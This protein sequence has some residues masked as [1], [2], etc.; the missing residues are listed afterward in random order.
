MW[1]VVNVCRMG[2]KGGLVSVCV[3]CEGLVSV[4]TCVCI[5]CDG[6]VCV[7]CVV[8]LVCIHACVHACV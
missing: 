6:L 2:C 1:G 3:G 4:Y 8:L 7:G 5:G